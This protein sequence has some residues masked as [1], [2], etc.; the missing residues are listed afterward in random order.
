MTA[1]TILSAGQR[2]GLTKSNHKR[3][4]QYSKPL[5]IS[6]RTTVSEQYA[7]CVDTLFRGQPS[8]DEIIKV[9]PRIKRPRR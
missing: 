5:A 1:H 9:A 2:A 6:R 8:F 3:S 7:D 4:R